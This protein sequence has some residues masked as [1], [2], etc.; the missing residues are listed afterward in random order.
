DTVWPRRSTNTA[1]ELIA[2][3]ENASSLKSIPKENPRLRAEY[4]VPL[5]RFIAVMVNVQRKLEEASNTYGAKERRF[6]SKIKYLFTYIDRDKCTQV[7]ESCRN[8]VENALAHLPDLWDVEVTQA[9]DLPERP[10]KS[11]PR[12]NTPH[13]GDIQSSGFLGVQ[14]DEEIDS[15]S[16]PRLEA[17]QSTVVVSSSGQDEEPVAPADQFNG[18]TKRRGWLGD[19][20]AAFN[21]AEGVGEMIPV[22]G[23]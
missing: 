14:G 16:V 10:G 6:R 18:S 9:E 19:M 20:K 7:L 15:G 12:T 3:I 11:Q 8:D 2:I 23:T 4:R 5:E 22:I 1:Q 21:V 17:A 13:S